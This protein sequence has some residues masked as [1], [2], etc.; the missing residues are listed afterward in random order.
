MPEGPWMLEEELIVDTA[1]DMA[2]V[3]AVTGD[4]SVAE[5]GVKEMLGQG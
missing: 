3:E 5:A 1:V 4:N 2:E